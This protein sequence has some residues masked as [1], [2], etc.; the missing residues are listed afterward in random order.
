MSSESLS[1]NGDA[2]TLVKNISGLASDIS[3]NSSGLY[4]LADNYDAS[5]DGTYSASPISTAF[6]G[7]FE[8]L[9]NTVSNV[10]ISDLSS[11]GDH[12]GLFSELDTGGAIRDF[13]LS[14]ISITVAGDGARVGGLVADNLGGLVDFDT[15][16]VQIS[17]TAHS[18]TR[19]LWVGGLVADNGSASTT[20]TIT[21][22]SASGWIHV[23]DDTVNNDGLLEGGLVAQN[24]VDGTH[25]TYSLV[26]YSG[27]SASVENSGNAIG[28]G[29]VNLV[30]GLVGYNFSSITNSTANGSVSGSTDGAGSAFGGLVGDENGF[31]ILSSSAS[32]SV[33]AGNEARVGGLIG[34]NAGTAT[35]SNASASGSVS[36]GNYAFVGGLIGSSPAPG[37]VFLPITGS[38]A[39][40]SV[41]G[42]AYSY[43]GGLVGFL[44]INV[45]N[46]TATGNVTGGTNS[47]VGG[48]V[49][50]VDAPGSI[51]G[52]SA[53]GI[54]SGY[55]EYVGGLAGYNT[56][57]ILTSSAL[58]Q[59]SGTLVGTQN[60]NS[61][62][63]GLVGYNY[64]MGTVSQSFSAP[65]EGS[66]AHAIFG[67]D[68]SSVGGLV[69]L[70][71]GT[72]GNSYSYPTFS[73]SCSG[74]TVPLIY[75]GTSSS[76]QSNVG[77]LIG[78]NFNTADLERFP[79]G[80]NQ[81]ERTLPPLALR[82]TSPRWGRKAKARPLFS[83]P[84]VGEV[85][86]AARRR[87]MCVVQLERIRSSSTN[88]EFLFHWIGRKQ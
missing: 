5:G 32:G 12:L 27:S 58:Q 56:G 70:N 63:G 39:T 34:V 71:N 23:D 9:G 81:I 10:T 85:P 24:W 66:N 6:S 72:V 75:G 73:V 37:P 79:I 57:D 30:G 83:S 22:S 82:A 8:G 74:C 25:G 69:G 14:N 67:G 3:S 61:Y 53:S 87:G 31:E 47:Y 20:G 46:S 38:T 51:T 48:L 76:V 45:E 65:I 78:Q 62:V 15:A 60:T 55:G 44:G 59:G 86:S 88:R 2:Y 36:G 49:G 28:A 29:A 21:N 50:Y 13:N 11:A 77:G 17:S 26:N 80:S 68:G 42:G 19:A 41:S 43:V 7:T 54:L 16:S 84:T 35:I 52:S 33:M 1:I 64:S 40:G 18:D 4:A